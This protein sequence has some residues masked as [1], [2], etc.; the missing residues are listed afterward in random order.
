MA[1]MLVGGQVS[2]AVGFLAMLIALLLG[3]LIGVLAGFIKALDGPLMRLTDLFLALPILPL[4]LVSIMLFRE[5]PL[6]SLYGPEN[7]IFILIVFMIGSPVGC[8]P[9]GIVR[10]DVLGIK[11][12]EFV[13]AAQALG[14]AAQDHIQAYSAECPKPNYGRSNAR[15]CQPHYYRVGAVVFG[16]WFPASFSHL[17]SVALR[18][19]KF[20]QITPSRVIWPGLFIALTVLSVN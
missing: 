3:T 14:R 19:T 9:P 1:A 6:R 16:A 20:I 7:G 11:E 18:R 8:I 5:T 10:G 2:L 13:L 12:R 15:D 17:G 4:L